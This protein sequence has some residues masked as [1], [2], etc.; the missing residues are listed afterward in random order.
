[1]QVLWDS[2]KEESMRKSRFTEEQIIGML[3]EAEAGGEVQEICRREGISRETFYR[4]RRKYGGLEVS[5]ARRLKA[6][7]GGEP[8][9][10]ADR[11]RSSAEPPGAEGHPGKRIVTA[12]ER[13]RVVERIQAAA[14]VSSVGRSGSPGSR[15]RRCDTRASGSPGGAS[16]PDQGSGPP[17][18]PMGL[19]VHP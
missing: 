17:V 10:E 4:W 13:R 8:S 18:A 1:M 11:G 15:R 12:R 14:G 5:D 7:R 9:A 6:A 19:P 16:G 3:R 2:T